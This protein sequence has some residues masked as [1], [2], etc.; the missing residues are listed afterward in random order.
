ME[1]DAAVLTVKWGPYEDRM[2]KCFEF[3]KEFAGKHSATKN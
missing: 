3:G 1:I 2:K